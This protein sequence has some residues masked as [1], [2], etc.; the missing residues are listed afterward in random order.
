[1]LESTNAPQ[2]SPVESYA[3]DGF[4]ILRNAIPQDVIQEA[5]SHIE[6]LMK[7]YPDLRPEHFHHP[8]MRDD[9]CWVNLVTHDKLLDIA[10]KFI[11]PNIV[12]FTS[13]YICKPPIDGHAVLW[14]QDG[15]YWRLEPMRAVTL[16]LA[17]DEST[18]ENGC[19]WMVPGS[20][21]LPVCGIKVQKDQDNMLGS[22]VDLDGLDQ[23]AADLVRTTPEVAIELQPG[24][25]SVHHP[26][27][28]HHSLPN[29]SN[30]RRCGLDIGYTD[31]GVR[32]MNEGL[33]E[34]PVLCRGVPTPGINRYRAW[35]SF[36]PDRSMAFR[37]QE[38]W[39]H[40]VAKHNRPDF[41]FM[42]PTDEPVDRMV[43]RMM[44]RIDAGTVKA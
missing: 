39:D 38:A 11:G 18:V 30:K 8:L 37:D 28:L 23:A 15:G 5:R 32:I 9:A 2:S 21:R 22:I 26:H 4:A 40:R 43:Q 44:Q 34:N 14:H 7:R 19:L 16:W 36:H 25:V 17:I 12:C 1:L 20:H 41:E 13:H 31:T 27:V 6:W 33:Y 42:S 35:P 29:R 3:R 10:E 24:D